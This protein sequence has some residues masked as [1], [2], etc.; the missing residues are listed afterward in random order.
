VTPTQR[1]YIISFVSGAFLAGVIAALDQ[2]ATT[3]KVDWQALAAAAAG[4]IVLFARDFL[5]NQSGARLEKPD[6][7]VG[8]APIPPH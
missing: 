3:G 7:Q 2:F 1:S 6:A 4:G 5:K 8:I